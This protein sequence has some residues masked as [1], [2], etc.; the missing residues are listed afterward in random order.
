MSA[1]R[2]GDHFV[3]GSRLC[4]YGF[5]P[6]VDQQ[7]RP[8]RIRLTGDTLVRFGERQVVPVAKLCPPKGAAHFYPNINLLG[9]GIGPVHL[10]LE[11]LD[12][13][14]ADPWYVVSDEPTDLNTLEEFGLRF[15]MEENFLDDKSNGFQVE[16]RGGNQRR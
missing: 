9:E 3:G 5:V 16:D 4:A 6:L 2:V 11:Q 7:H 1:S 13:L 15:D 12:E 10:A 14:N 8:Y